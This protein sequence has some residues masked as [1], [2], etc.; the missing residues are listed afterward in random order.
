MDARDF[1]KEEFVTLRAESQ[2]HQVN[3]SAIF[4]LNVT[5]IGVGVAATAADNAIALPLVAILTSVLWMRYIDHVVAIFRVAAYISCRLSPRLRT[6][7]SGEDDGNLFMW[8][9]YLRS[10]G[11][12]VGDPDMWLPAMTSD[13]GSRARRALRRWVGPELDSRKGTVIASVAFFVPPPVMSILYIVHAQTS[14]T[15]TWWSWPAFTLSMAAWAYATVHVWLTARWIDAIDETITKAA[16][17]ES[18]RKRRLTG[19]RTL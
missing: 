8:E 19:V 13:R 3:A 6:A 7:F 10:P 17:W 12:P 5:G 2:F 1:D 9:T 18:R 4:A 16:G 14:G 15:S 11:Q